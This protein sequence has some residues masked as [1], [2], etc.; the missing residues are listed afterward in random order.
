MPIN[1]NNVNLQLHASSPTPAAPP[2]LAKIVEALKADVEVRSQNPDDVIAF[3]DADNTEK[4]LAL[5]DKGLNNFRT[6]IIAI[7]E[8]IPISSGEVSENSAKLSKNIGENKV[9][10][11]TNL[12]RLIELHRQLREYT[13]TAADL[14]FQKLYPDLHTPGFTSWLDA[15]ISKN[16]IGDGSNLISEDGIMQTI[17]NI[18]DALEGQASYDPEYQTIVNNNKTNTIF[19]SLCEY[20]VYKSLIQKTIDYLGQITSIDKRLSS[21]WRIDRF[22]KFKDFSPQDTFTNSEIADLFSTVD[23]TLLSSGQDIGKRLLGFRDFTGE[24][25]DTD[26]FLNTL[27]QLAS[28]ISFKDSSS[29]LSSLELAKDEDI[30]VPPGQIKFG[31]RGDLAKS[32]NQLKNISLNGCLTYLGQNTEDVRQTITMQEISLQAKNKITKSNINEIFK[33]IEKSDG[34]SLPYYDKGAKEL[35]A[36]MCYDICSFFINS[37]GGLKTDTGTVLYSSEVSSDTSDHAFLLNSYNNDSLGYPIYTPASIGSNDPVNKYSHFI[38]RTLGMPWFSGLSYKYNS[39]SNKYFYERQ[40]SLPNNDE[41]NFLGLGTVGLDNSSKGFGS[42][43][44][45]NIEAR[46]SNEANSDQVIY[47]PLESKES[48]ASNVRAG[49]GNSTFALTSTKYFVERQVEKVGGEN[50]ENIDFASLLNFS[51]EYKKSS[52]NLIEDLLTLFPD[53][54][55]TKNIP[56]NQ[57]TPKKLYPLFDASP[58]S[59]FKSFIAVIVE[60]L[61]KIENES[62]KDEILPLLSVFLYDK[63]NQQKTNLFLACLWSTIY[64]KGEFDTNA[65]EDRNKINRR[66]TEAYNEKIVNKFFKYLGFSYNNSPKKENFDGRNSSEY[67]VYLGRSGNLFKSDNIKNKINGTKELN[68][69]AKNKSKGAVRTLTIEAKKIDDTFDKAFGRGSNSKL[70]NVRKKTVMGYSDGVTTLFFDPSG[71]S[72]LFTQLFNFS[73]YTGAGQAALTKMNA[74]GPDIRGSEGSNSIFDES[75]VIGNF[76]MFSRSGIF[77]KIKISN[78]VERIT[79]DIGSARFGTLLGLEGQHRLLI[80]FQWI[81]GLLNNTISVGAAT[82]SNGELLLKMYPEQIQGVIDGLLD[83]IGEAKSY[84]DGNSPLSNAYNEAFL[85]AKNYA[86]DTLDALNV[87]QQ[88]I[89]DLGG[90]FACHASALSSGGK[91][92]KD[93]LSGESQGPA[94]KMA[95][96]ALRQQGVFNDYVTLSSEYSPFQT[97]TGMQNLFSQ[98]SNSLLYTSNYFNLNKISLIDKTLSRKGYGF[99]TNEAS[100][101]KSILNVGIPNSMI[102]SLQKKAYKETGDARYLDS[103]YVCISVFKKDHFNPHYLFYPKNFIF[104]TSANILDMSLNTNSMSSHLKDFVYD[105]SFDKVLNSIEITRFILDNNGKIKPKISKG[106]GESGGI[107]SKEVLVNH[108]HSYV[109]QEYAKL[110]TGLNFDEETFLLTRNSINDSNPPLE[111]N[112]LVTEYRKILFELKRIYPEVDNDPQLKSEVFRMVSCIKQSI[113]FSFTSRF[114]KIIT[115]KSFDRIYSIFVNEKD[116]VLVPSGGEISDIFNLESLGENKMFSLEGK[117]SGGGL[118]SLKKSF[119]FAN[120]NSA[121]FEKYAEKY[122]KSLDPSVPE[123]YNYH[124]VTSLLPLEFVEGA[125]QKEKTEENNV[126]NSNVQQP[127]GTVVASNLINNSQGVTFSRNIPGIN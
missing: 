8:Y 27:G 24:A 97:L 100:G 22:Y 66:I 84:D 34:T 93:I 104:D 19:L 13:L 69:Q 48:Q 6:E 102:A 106:Y 103:P 16:F 114:K 110:T 123:A 25:S 118:N 87:R 83:S 85:S 51:E 112:D 61:K 86:K 49:N 120:V 31:V 65:P 14:L 52:N 5:S 115:P 55:I 101:N 2:V 107:F 92:V 75:E 119:D 105:R 82:S 122:L 3:T 17:Q 42:F 38:A 9:I 39:E 53:D 126:I 21:D 124:I 98:K 117:L 91:D 57:T 37:F 45:E 74:K 90:I 12:S 108:L 99:L 60:D 111:R 46:R 30:E 18:L 73:V 26:Y 32:I 41:E 127:S 44:T 70:K 71:I 125:I 77:G 7:M 1:T 29:I 59:I 80:M 121:G 4:Y 50:F 89:R 36:A 10:S 62:D 58:K 20:I 96:N 67:N 95:I 28:V 11:A 79:E 63:D 109:L 15:E 116:F 43:S 35:F 78:E 72:K 76:S 68:S 56:N 40:K 54:E 113:P 33:N 94:G 88:F 81:S 47:A 23:N 64:S